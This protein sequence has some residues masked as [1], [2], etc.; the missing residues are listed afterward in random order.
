MELMKNHYHLLLSERDGGITLFL[1]KL[2][3]RYFNENTSDEAIY[4][5]NTKIPIVRQSIFSM[6]CIIFI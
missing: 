4:F 3:V 2:S 5:G 6:F 1:R